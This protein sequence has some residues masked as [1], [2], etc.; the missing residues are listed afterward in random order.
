MESLVTV[1]LRSLIDSAEALRPLS[2]AETTFQVPGIFLE[3]PVDQNLRIA[4]QR[5]H[6]GT[7]IDHELDRLLDLI[8]LGHRRDEL[9]TNLSHGQ[10]QWLEIARRVNT[11]FAD[12]ADLSGIVVTSGTDTLEELAYFLNLTVKSD[13]PVVVVG[14]MR[15]PSQIGYEGAANLL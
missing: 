5:V 11:L 14:S 8:G 10:Q 2:S 4:L 6:R 9:A 3:L 1:H 13:K 12:D 15:N 7:A